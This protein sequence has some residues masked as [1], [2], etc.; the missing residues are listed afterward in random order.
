M[1]PVPQIA[2]PIASHVTSLWYRIGCACCITAL[3]LAAPLRVAAGDRDEVLKSFVLPDGWLVEQVAGAPLVEHPLMAGF[4]DRGR[5]YVAEAAGV[6]LKRAELEA[7]TPNSI[8]RLQD[9]DG[10]GRFD[11]HTV[12][13]DKLTFPQ[14]ALWH[15]GAVYAASSGAIWKFVDADDD[16][17]AELREPIVK[18][19]GYTGNAADVHGPFLAP[20]G[21]LVWCEGRHGHEIFDR[22]GK[23]VSKGQAARIFSSRLDG[24]DVQVHCGGGMDNPVEVDFTPEGEMLGDVNLFYRQ[25]GDCFVHWQHGGV[26]PREDQP[27]CLAEFRRTGPLLGE[28]ADLGHVA[29]SGLC[30]TRSVER[31]GTAEDPLE[32]FVTE[33]NSHKVVRLT[34]RRHGAT[35]EADVQDFLHSTHDDFHP[36]DVLEDADGSLLAIDTGGWFLNGCPTSQVAKPEAL[37]GIYRLRRRDAKP[38]DDPR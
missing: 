10:D 38:L 27:D 32:W 13:A 12:F 35:F 1:A 2:L 25:R 17:V 34:T 29:V 11:K 6:N 37:G 30:R 9:V 31:K 18:G 19:F 22:G 16:G 21:R 20:S 7:Q 33:F 15:R 36:T 5:L 23:L 4:D 8:R 28:V 24:S 14:G 26:Y 3:W